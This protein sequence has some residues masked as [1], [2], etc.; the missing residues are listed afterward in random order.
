[1]KPQHIIVEIVTFGTEF[2]RKYKCRY[3]YMIQKCSCIQPTTI[4]QVTVPTYHYCYALKLCYSF[5][6][7]PQS[8]YFMPSLKIVTAH[9]HL[10]R[11]IIAFSCMLHTTNIFP[12]SIQCTTIPFCAC[13]F[14]FHIYMYSGINTC[15]TS[16]LLHTAC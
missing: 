10:D 3:R 15:M 9:D 14:T 1:M 12:M 11:L 8:Y 16:E 4:L 6:F 7:P 5:L 2:K 13:E